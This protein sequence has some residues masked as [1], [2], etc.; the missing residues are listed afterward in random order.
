MATKDLPKFRQGTGH[1][2]PVKVMVERIVVDVDYPVLRVAETIENILCLAT[3]V[4]T[5]LLPVT[6]EIEDAQ[7]IL[8]KM[9]DGDCFEC[10]NKDKCLACRIND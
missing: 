6:A 7:N 9:Y 3:M 8:A 1:V 2:F 5:G 4:A 10:P